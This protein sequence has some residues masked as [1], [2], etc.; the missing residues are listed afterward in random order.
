MAARAGLCVFGLMMVLA[1]GCGGGGGAAPTPTPTPTATATASSTPLPPTATPTLTPEPIWTPA[2]PAEPSTAGGDCDD[3]YPNGAPYEAE[4]GA[5]IRLRPSGAPPPQPPYQ[6]SAFT[7]DEELREV[8]LE[9][10][11]DQEEHFAVVVKELDGGTGV[12]RAE[13]RPFYAA[14]LYKTWVMLEA[15]RQ[16]EAAL[17]SFDARYT[18]TP[19]YEAFGLNPGELAACD[20]VAAGEALRR[21][22]ALSDNVA[23][24]LLLDL[25]GAGNVNIALSGLG[26]GGS[27]FRIDEAQAMPTTA[28]DMALLLEAL[29]A[30]QVVSA[31]ASAEMLDL[32]TSEVVGGRLPALLPPG[33]RI[34]HKTGTWP[35]A[36][37]DAGI[38]YSPAATY[39][40][41]VLTDFGYSDDGPGAIARLS[42]AVY[43]YYNGR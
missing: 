43:D 6:V 14:S 16:R 37:H 33:T 13:G 34:A 18:V 36:T 21:A 29:A 32:L 41:V 2:T 8:V 19:H 28:A 9:A 5:P 35:T 25:V 23:A 39:V 26:M 30:G 20:E 12:R 17:L 15:F 31:A 42:L 24:N 38:V 1:A 40:I 22:L 3:P 11:G 4:E 10:L 27:G 7:P